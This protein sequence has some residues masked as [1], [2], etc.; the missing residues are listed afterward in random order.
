MNETY[1]PKFM[2]R[3]AELSSTALVSGKGLP[4]GCVIVKNGDIVGE[5]HNE[6]FHRINPTAHAEMVAIEDACTRAGE[7]SLNGCDLYTTM[8]PCPMCAAAIYWAN[9]RSVFFA[10]SGQLG[11]RYGFN[12]DYI[13]NDLAKSPRERIIPHFAC[14]A[15]DVVDIL[16]AWRKAGSRASQPFD[17]C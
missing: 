2:T 4:I 15:P 11:A 16:D 3:A 7:L 8:E 17:V 9:I 6:I 13:R 12:D 5:G 1:D 14:D 10:A